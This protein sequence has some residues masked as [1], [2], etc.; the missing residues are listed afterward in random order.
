MSPAHAPDRSLTGK[1]APY[2]RYTAAHGAPRGTRTSSHTIQL[3]RAGARP[4]ARHSAGSRR[5]RA[6][7]RSLRSSSTRA[8]AAAAARRSTSVRSGHARARQ[9]RGRGAAHAR[10]AAVRAAQRVIVNDHG[11]VVAG[12]V[13]I[14]F[15][16]NI[17]GM[18]QGGPEGVQGV[19]VSRG[20]VQAAVRVEHAA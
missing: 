2:A 4:A 17:I 5:S 15:K 10:A 9:R 19:L 16:A 12:Y 20:A 8:P 18:I 3:T 1:R 13:D 11:D 6:A 14:A 7:G